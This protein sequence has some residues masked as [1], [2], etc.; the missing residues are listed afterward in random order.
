MQNNSNNLR[1]H[2]NTMIS[3][4]D[5]LNTDDLKFQQYREYLES[6]MSSAFYGIAIYQPVFDADDK[7][8]D[9]RIL[10]TNTEVPGNFGLSVADVTGK[11]CREVYPGIFS[12]GVFEKLVDCYIERKPQTYEVESTEGGNHIWFSAAVEYVNGAVTVSSKNCTAEKEAASHL[13]LMNTFLTDTNKQ[14][15]QLILKEFSES[16]SSYKTG[17]EFFDFLLAEL[18]SKTKVDYAIIAELTSAENE[19]I[20]LSFYVAG[21]LTDNFTFDISDNPAKEVVKGDMQTF[22]SGL[23]SKFPNSKMFADFNV[24]G[25]IA[26]PLC[27]KLDHCLGFIGVMHKS[28]I[29]DPQYIISLLKV[30]AKRCEM[31]LERQHNEKLLEAKNIEL[32]K[33]NKD[34]ASFTYIASHD[35]QEPLRKIRMFN[36]RILE[37]DE[38][39][40]SQNSLSYLNSINATAGRMQNLID[41]LLSYSSMDS[42][43]LKKEKVDLKRVL[44]DVMAMMD[45]ILE[46]KKVT[47]NASELPSIYAIP[48]QFQQLLYNI[49]SNAIKYSKADESPV[50]SISA[51]KILM[52]KVGF[53]KIAIADNGIG[54]DPQYKERIFEVFQRL[55]GKKEYAGT[56]VGLAICKKIVQN[57]HGHITADG[58]PGVGAIFNIYIPEKK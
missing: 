9:F 22:T 45:D 29:K 10:F 13:E 3:S 56:G 48:L 17:K 32:Q 27:D 19:M 15:E 18:V 53:W 54:F 39:N 12:N 55:H 21:E 51:E 41:A 47:I 40:L 11:T 1:D 2:V 24:E 49:I 37:K 50:I 46:A 26:H 31:E 44:K 43:D 36:S 23:R 20:T 14:L 30:A 58:T 7:I 57:H 5:S 42:D 52:D 6:V 33:Q 4:A 28:E 35:L 16:F 34:L 25:F 8:E 38:H